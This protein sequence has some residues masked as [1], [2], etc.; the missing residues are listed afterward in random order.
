MSLPE[1][2]YVVVVSHARYGEARARMVESLSDWPRDR[3]VIVLNG[4]DAD[5]TSRQA[6]GSHVVRFASNL[7]EYT[8]FF[9]PRVLGAGPGSA[10]L[11]VHDTCTAG[12]DFA[13]RAREAFS[14]F[15]E[16]DLDVLWCSRGGQC[17]VCVFGEAV[18]ERARQ[19]WGQMT[20]VDKRR[21]IYWEHNA[22][23]QSL[24][25]QDDLRQAYVEHASYVTGV[26]VPY[27]S[28]VP[29]HT[30]YFPFLDLKKWYYNMD[31]AD[32]HPEQP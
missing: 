23:R 31:A 5:Q 13:A 3:L 9:V 7:Y 10:F 27:S 29:R 16:E 25:G 11:L 8:G 28:G 1:G 17:N 6:D 14:R 18:A 30:L 19:L 22:D 24:K 20:T 21:A 2:D 15:R 26:E 4:E 12:P 32:V